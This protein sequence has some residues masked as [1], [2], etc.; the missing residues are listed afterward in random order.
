MRPQRR[1]GT[2]ED[3]KKKIL[4]PGN[5]KPGLRLLQKARVGVKKNRAFGSTL[6]PGLG[7]SNS[8][9]ANEA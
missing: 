9:K 5:F 1:E 4:E 8:F 7:Y 6:R 3:A 2:K